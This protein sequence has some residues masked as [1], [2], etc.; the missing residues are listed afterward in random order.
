MLV[1]SPRS[2]GARMVVGVGWVVASEPA[3]S[4]GSWAPSEGG[5]LFIDGAQL[6]GAGHPAGSC[7]VLFAAGLAGDQVDLIL[8]PH[9]GALDHGE[10]A[11]AFS[12]DLVDDG[13]R[14]GQLGKPGILRQRAGPGRE[15]VHGR[16]V[17]LKLDEGPLVLKECLQWPSQS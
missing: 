2:C 16:V 3:S 9:L 12:G 6:V 13:Q 11:A 1:L 17:A 5:D 14:L 8:E 10:A 7:P 15:P 4:S